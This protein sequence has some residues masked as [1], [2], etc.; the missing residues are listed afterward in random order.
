MERKGRKQKK[1]KKK[2][3]DSTLAQREERKERQELNLGNHAS[4]C[5]TVGGWTGDSTHSV[6]GRTGENNEKGKLHKGLMQLSQQQ[7]GPWPHPIGFITGALLA[8]LPCQITG[9]VLAWWPHLVLCRVTS[10]INA[11]HV[12]SKYTPYICLRC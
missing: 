6:K 4:H 9:H 8:E 5:P 3:S 12:D 10:R 2:T 11:P 7:L 1:K